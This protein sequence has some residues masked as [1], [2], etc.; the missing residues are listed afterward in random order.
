[1]YS[2][3]WMRGV[4]YYKTYSNSRITAVGLQDADLDSDQ[5]RIYPLRTEQDVYREP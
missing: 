2:C 5:L 4:Y 1:M 3:C